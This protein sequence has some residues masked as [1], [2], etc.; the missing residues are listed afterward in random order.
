MWKF[1]L[2]NSYEWILCD[3]RFSCTC[4]SVA[5]K[6]YWFCVNFNHWKKFSAVNSIFG[7][8]AIMTAF[9]T[10]WVSIFAEKNNLFFFSVI[11]TLSIIVLLCT[12][13]VIWELLIFFKMTMFFQM[14]IHNTMR[15]KQDEIW[16][17]IHIVAL[18]S[19]IGQG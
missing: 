9:W 4:I 1:V 11:E 14:L 16:Q 10:E 2:Q 12:Y 3:H 15:E 7:S 17:L 19:Y 5:I 6:K 8:T 13:T 18:N